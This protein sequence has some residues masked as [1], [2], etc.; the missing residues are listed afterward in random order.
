M[1]WSVV[2]GPL[3]VAV[4]PLELEISSD[5]APDANDRSALYFLLPDL[6]LADSSSSFTSAFSI[7]AATRR[8][9][10][11]ALQALDVR[12]ALE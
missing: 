1:E 2:S 11:A 9:G 4:V 10:D 12:A 7:D 6:Y 8:R 5:F 3:S